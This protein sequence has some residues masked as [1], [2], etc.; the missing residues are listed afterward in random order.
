MS[1][2]SHKNSMQEGLFH[3]RKHN[4]TQEDYFGNSKLLIQWLVASCDLGVGERQKRPSAGALA[5]KELPLI[6]QKLLTASAGSFY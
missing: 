5:L 3:S 1:W 6:N 2:S 4:P